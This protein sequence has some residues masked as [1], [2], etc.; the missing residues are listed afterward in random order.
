MPFVSWM[1]SSLLS[2]FQ[3]NIEVTPTLILTGAGAFVALLVLS[4]IVSAIDS[5]PLVRS[6]DIDNVISTSL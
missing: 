3:L 5:V 1:S 4:S 6:Y 2:I